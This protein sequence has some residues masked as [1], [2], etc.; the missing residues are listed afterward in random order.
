MFNYVVRRLLQAVPLVL[1]VSLVIFVLLQSTGDPLATMGGRQPTRSED[2]E[3][4]RRQLGL[5]QPILTQYIYWLIG[6]DWT[7]FDRDGDG[8]P[9][10]PGTRYG[11]LRGD[12][13]QSI[14]TKT[15]AMKLIAERMPNTLLLMVT[16]EIIIIIFALIIGVVSAVRQYS[17]FD[18]LLT[19]AS[20]VTFSMPVFLMGF[21]LLYIFAVKFREWGLPYF[22]TI[23]NPSNANNLA[24]LA[25]YMALPVATLSLISIAAY[26]RYIRS[27]M[28]EV[29]N[30]DYIR[31]ARSKGLTERR[32]LY[33]HAFK[34]AAL[35]LATLIGLDIPF[36]LG[37][38]IV[39][40]RIF[41]WPGMG[42]L[43]ID[44]LGRLDYAVVMGL[45]ILITVAVIVFQ[46]I[47][48]L[49]YTLLDP[50]IRYS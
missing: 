9:E 47:T 45:L 49:V 13:G 29:I 8:E 30:S 38:A 24:E 25:W 20:F 28:L 21:G 17:L 33:G 15:P 10:S 43:F 11:V 4:L 19:G 23:S 37:G 32:I 16:A 7:L 3:R 6:N 27:N 39:T 46:L 44:H 36:F 18:N 2:R 22:P 42:R 34:N 26:S 41:S 14:V 40:E 31:T 50:R 5:D 48:D 1:I 35:P 12:F